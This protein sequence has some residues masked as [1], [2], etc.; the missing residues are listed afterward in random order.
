[1]ARYTFDMN[2]DDSEEGNGVDTTTLTVD[3][4]TENL[5]DLVE[6]FYWFL[7]A[8]GYSYVDEV[9]AGNCSFSL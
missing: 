2:R 9:K 4:E 5:Y 1:M 7:K 3:F 8:A 6:K